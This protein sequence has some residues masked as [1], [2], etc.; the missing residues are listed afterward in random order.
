MT[1]KVVVRKPHVLDLAE[2]C[3]DLVTLRAA[4]PLIVSMALV[5]ILTGNIAFALLTVG[6]TSFVH[7][8]WT[9]LL[10]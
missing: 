1:D 5:A 4:P 7:A 8:F 2:S 3:K 6:I 10:E 9:R